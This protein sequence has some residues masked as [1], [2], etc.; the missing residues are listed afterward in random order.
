M[1]IGISNSFTTMNYLTL[2]GDMTQEKHQKGW[3]T[4]GHRLK[5]L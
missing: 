3:L 5:K 2:Y 4:I 1:K